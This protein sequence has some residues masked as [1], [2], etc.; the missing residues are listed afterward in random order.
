MAIIPLN[1]HILAIPAIHAM[2]AILA[3]VRRAL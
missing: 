2:L 3:I 1:Y